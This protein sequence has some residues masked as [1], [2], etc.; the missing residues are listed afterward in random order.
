MKSVY[1]NLILL[2]FSFP[3]ANCQPATTSGSGPFD[4]LRKIH[5]EYINRELNLTSEEQDKFWPVYEE[6][7][8]KR[9]ELKLDHVSN[10]LSSTENMSDTELEKALNKKMENKEKFSALQKTYFEK[11]KHILPVRKL[12][13]LEEVEMEFKHKMKEHVKNKM[14]HH[15]RW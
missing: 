4:K 14:H 5:K 12:A 11:L 9:R 3:Y 7:L 1:L 13:R 10:H 15:R 2:L 6:F 8:E